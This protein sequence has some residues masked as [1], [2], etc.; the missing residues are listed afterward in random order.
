MRFAAEMWVS[1]NNRQ[2]DYELCAIEVSGVSFTITNVVTG[3]L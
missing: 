3:L 1:Q 2:G